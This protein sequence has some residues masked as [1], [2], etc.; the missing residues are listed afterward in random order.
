MEFLKFISICITLI[1]LYSGSGVAGDDTGDYDPML[2]VAKIKEV[3]ETILSD[4][5]YLSLEPIKKLQI[6]IAFYNILEDPNT[7]S[8]SNFVQVQRVGHSQKTKQP[9]ESH[10]SKPCFHCGSMPRLNKQ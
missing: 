3:F 8:Y 5:E 9:R 1:I 7:N 10:F 6:L 4:P 2:S